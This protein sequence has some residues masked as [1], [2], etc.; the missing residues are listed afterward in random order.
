VAESARLGQCV[1]VDGAIHVDDIHKR[2]VDEALGDPRESVSP[3]RRR[4]GTTHEMSWTQCRAGAEHCTRRP[5]AGTLMAV[6]CTE[7]V[8]DLHDRAGRNGRIVLLEGLAGRGAS[9]VREGR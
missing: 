7:S 5:A 6:G 2:P 3:L 8:P 9:R 4:E 1:L